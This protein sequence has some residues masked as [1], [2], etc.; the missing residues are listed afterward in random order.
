MRG[1]LALMLQYL[2]QASA[3]A[4]RGPGEVTL[5]CR[6]LLP[7]ILADIRVL[8]FEGAAIAFRCNTAKQYLLT[9]CY[10]GIDNVPPYATRGT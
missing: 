4:D 7:D 6:A 3:F 8:F 2:H 5:V 10:H 1:S 9:S